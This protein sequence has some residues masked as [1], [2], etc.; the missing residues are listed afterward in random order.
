MEVE[1]TDTARA[2]AERY[3]EFIAERSNDGSSSDQ[4]WNGLLD[5]IFT[6]EVLPARCPVIPERA[7]NELQVRQLLYESHRILFHITG[8][9]VRILRIYPSWGRPLQ[10]LHQHTKA[11]KAL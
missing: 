6:L 1:I 2:E 3:A 9:T 8:Q 10:S 4:W 7:G 11:G 5:A